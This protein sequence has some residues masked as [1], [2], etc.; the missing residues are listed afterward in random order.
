[1][2]IRKIERKCIIRC[3]NLYIASLSLLKSK[4]RSIDSI[5]APLAANDTKF[6]YKKLNLRK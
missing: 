1:M 4:R 2:K 5:S 3:D 6:I